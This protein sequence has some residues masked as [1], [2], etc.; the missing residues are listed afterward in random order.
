MQTLVHSPP[1]RC[2]VLPISLM[3]RDHGGVF[4]GVHRG[5]VEHLLARERVGDLAEHRAREALL[6]HRRQDGR[7]A[8]AGGGV[9]HQRCVVAQVDRVDL[10]VA[11]A[12]CDW[13]SIMT[14]VW[15]AGSAA[16]SRRWGWLGWTWIDWIHNC[17][18]R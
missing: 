1:A 13:K 11:K 12:I 7:H 2:A 6:G 8:E 3:L 16:W 14:S 4:P 5:A 18:R 17:F 10:L 9:G 15:S